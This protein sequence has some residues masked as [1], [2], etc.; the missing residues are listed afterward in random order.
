MESHDY[1]G[2]AFDVSIVIKHPS[3]QEYLII[4]GL[5]FHILNFDN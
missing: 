3:F 5:L 2:F 4:N 1:N